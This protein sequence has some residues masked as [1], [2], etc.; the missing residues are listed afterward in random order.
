MSGC[1][2]DRLR[3]AA[4]RRVEKVRELAKRNMVNI[5]DGQWRMN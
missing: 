5:I 2:V 4:D 1:D 3:C